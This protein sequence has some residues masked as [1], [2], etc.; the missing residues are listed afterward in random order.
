M[1]ASRM[2]TYVAETY[3]SG[4]RQ[5][6]VR[7]KDV[8]DGGRPGNTARDFSDNVYKYYA[9]RSGAVRSARRNPSSK[10]AH[11]TCSS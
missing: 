2:R 7:F 9:G 6:E 3:L 5:D 1:P 11:K 4:E 8:R 10:N